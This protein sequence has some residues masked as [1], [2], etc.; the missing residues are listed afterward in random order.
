MNKIYI[1]LAAIT[2]SLTACDNSD[3]TESDNSVTRDIKGSEIKIVAPAGFVPICEKSISIW[4]S[5]NKGVSDTI[6]LLTCY[7]RQGDWKSVDE[8]TADDL[9]PLMTV[10]IRKNMIN[11]SMTKA[12]FSG[13]L[14]VINKPLDEAGIVLR[15][16]DAY[17][18][19]VEASKTIRM[20][21]Q[22]KVFDTLSVT[23]LTL[24]KDK[25]LLLVLED[26]I[27]DETDISLT[28]QLAKDWVKLMQDTN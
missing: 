1:L 19:G 28:Q 7:V 23:C 13:M 15:E 27:K 22:E 6:H 18:Y 10:A 20:Q 16:D 11:E 9:N 25:Y 4:D 2:I 12:E 3:S 24:V 5:V 26:E 21:Q 8:V 17:C 14:K